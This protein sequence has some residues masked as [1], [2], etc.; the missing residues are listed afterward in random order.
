MKN[1]LDHLMGRQPDVE[2]S[3]DVD[4]ELRLGASER[5]EGGDRHLLSLSQIEP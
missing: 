3:V 5:G 4:L 2:R 1:R